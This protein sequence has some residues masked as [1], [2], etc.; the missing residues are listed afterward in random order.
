MFTRL[1]GTF[2]GTPGSLGS[3]VERVEGPFNPAPSECYID[4]TRHSHSAGI[5]NSPARS[6]QCQQTTSPVLRGACVVSMSPQSSHSCHS[7]AYN[8]AILRSIHLYSGVRSSARTPKVWDAETRAG[9]LGH[10]RICLP[11]QVSVETVLPYNLPY[12]SRQLPSSGIF[13]RLQ[14]PC[15]DRFTPSGAVQKNPSGRIISSIPERCSR[16]RVRPVVSISEFR[17]RPRT[18]SKLAR[19]MAP[20]LDS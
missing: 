20:T 18:V 1:L 6:A 13:A 14:H 11:A 5:S 12:K 17:W 8:S 9:H 7:S 10:V 15:S 3:W 19:R 4:P 2:S 16:P